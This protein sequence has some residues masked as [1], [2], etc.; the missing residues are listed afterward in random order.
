MGYNLSTAALSSYI[1]SNDSKSRGNKKSS[2][3][4][5]KLFNTERKDM[6]APRFSHTQV[7][8]DIY[9]LNLQD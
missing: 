1:A 6:D 8:F 2:N 9:K 4:I 3:K 5:K 7:S